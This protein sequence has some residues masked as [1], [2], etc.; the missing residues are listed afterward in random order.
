M[1]GRTGPASDR[2]FLYLASRHT[3][4]CV[5]CTSTPLP[6][7]VTFSPPWSPLSGETLGKGIQG[8]LFLKPRTPRKGHADTYEASACT[9][10]RSS[11]DTYARQ[12]FTFPTLSN[13]KHAGACA[14]LACWCLL[15]RRESS[16]PR[17]SQACHARRPPPPS[18]IILV[19]TEERQ[20]AL[21]ARAGHRLLFV[22]ARMR[23]SDIGR[24][25][26][27]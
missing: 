16:V 18:K 13:F 14:A 17:I 26:T 24:C 19:Q 21:K 15:S 22:C 9:G 20:R 8:A 12:T 2:L 1:E 7:D 27:N 23:V 11:V 5:R 4:A 25:A 3:N 6:V 10:C